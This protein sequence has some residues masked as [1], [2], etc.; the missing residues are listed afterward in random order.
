MF[1]C[2]LELQPSRVVTSIFLMAL[3]VVQ[4]LWFSPMLLALFLTMVVNTKVTATCARTLNV[5]R[6]L[7]MVIGA[8]A[9][10]GDGASISGTISVLSVCRAMLLRILVFARSPQKTNI[11]TIIMSR[12]F[13]KMYSLTHQLL[14]TSTQVPGQKFISS[15]QLFMI[16]L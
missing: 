9:V 3:V 1:S 5:Y 16:T 8:V 11:G 12:I 13:C 4:Y 7:M 10:V 6:I 2:R 15:S 14:R